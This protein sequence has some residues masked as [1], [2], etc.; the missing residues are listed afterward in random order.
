MPDLALVVVVPVFNRPRVV[1][2]ALESVAAQ[3][4]T[5]SR[6]IIVDDGSTDDTAACVERWISE[7]RPLFDTRLMRQSNQGAAAARNHGAAAAG[8]CELLAFLDSDDLW[9]ADFLERVVA[10]F[11][12]QPEAVAASS[13]RVRLNLSTGERRTKDLRAMQGQVTTTLVVNGPPGLPNTTVSARAFHSIGGF[14]PALRSGQDYDLF[15]RLSLLGPW[16]HVPGAPVTIRDQTDSVMGGQRQITSQTG[17]A[18]T[19]VQILDRFIHQ[20]GGGRA[21]PEPLWR[22]R[23]G[24]LWFRAGQALRQS[25]QRAEAAG[26]FRRAVELSPWHWRA[27]WYAFTTRATG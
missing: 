9:P 14:D 6:L 23:L 8:E 25:H 4:L 11:S 27:R 19:R 16:T 3:T 22:R 5:P 20:G 24:P 17:R 1:L 15:L 2:E 12:R 26:C 13:D 18:V 7:K 21:V 10:A